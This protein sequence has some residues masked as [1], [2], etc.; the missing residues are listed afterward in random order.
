MIF[1]YQNQFSTEQSIYGEVSEVNFNV[2]GTK[3]NITIKITEIPSKYKSKTTYIFNAYKK[4]K[5]EGIDINEN[6]KPLYLFFSEIQPDYKTYQILES[7]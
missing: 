7:D 2:S 3:N 4:S 6:H 5:V 1:S